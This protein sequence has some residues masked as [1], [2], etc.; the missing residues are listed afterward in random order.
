MIKLSSYILFVLTIALTSVAYAAEPW[1]E[2]SWLEARVAVV[3]VQAILEKSVAVQSIRKSIDRISE[4]LQ[5]EM[6]AKEEALQNTEKEIIKKRGVLKEEDFDR[7]VKEFN[8]KVSEAQRTVQ[9]KRTKLEHAHSQAM[10]KVHEVTVQIID[11]LS[12]E[13]GFNIAAPSSQVLYATDALN[14]T[15]EVISRLNN[16]LK[17][18]QVNYK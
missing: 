15:G 3:D 14:I 7:E 9:E 8:R 11:A 1:A 12:K 16:Q 17:S 5:K 10:A 4:D 2:K 13:R 6:S 18:V